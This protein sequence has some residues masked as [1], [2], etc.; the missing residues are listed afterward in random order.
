MSGGLPPEGFL[1]GASM[2]YVMQVRGT[3][4]LF[5]LFN[6][7]ACCHS[8]GLAY[9]RDA[10]GQVRGTGGLSCVGSGQTLSTVACCDAHDHEC[11]TAACSCLPALC[12]DVLRRRWLRCTPVGGALCRPQAPR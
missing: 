5:V 2:V 1:Y 4:G 6:L 3:G 8:L 7:N 10:L 12:C 9:E 11:V